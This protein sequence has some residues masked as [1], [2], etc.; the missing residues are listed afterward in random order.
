MLLW[1]HPQQC[2]MSPLLLSS[3]DH[4]LLQLSASSEDVSLYHLC[5]LFPTG[6]DI[7]LG[8]GH[9]CHHLQFSWVSIYCHLLLCT[10]TFNL[11]IA[12]IKNN[13]DWWK[14]WLCKPKGSAK[15]KIVL[16]WQWKALWIQSLAVW[17]YA[18]LC[19]M[20]QENS[21]LFSLRIRPS[22]GCGPFRFSFTMWE[23]IP[24]SFYNLTKT[25]QEFLFFIG[26]QAFSI[27]LCVLSWW[28]KHWNNCWYTQSSI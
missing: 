23:I 25:T 5:L 9:S 19:Y 7:W 11:A 4:T 13:E 16:S 6:V 20:V 8:P 28:V 2:L 12:K 22:M 26:S 10:V 15:K 21:F 27:P 1:F 18:I 14:W 3:L 24:T 17:C